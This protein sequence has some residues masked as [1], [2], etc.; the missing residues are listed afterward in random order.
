MVNVDQNKYDVLEFYAG[1]RRL[2]KL[3]TGLGQTCVAMDVLYDTLGDNKTTNNSMDIN[4]CGGFTPLIQ[5]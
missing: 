3:A 4:T 5:K 2:A 1:A